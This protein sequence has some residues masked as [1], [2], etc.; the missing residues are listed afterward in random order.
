MW[1]LVIIILLL[2]FIIIMSKN[3]SSYTS[4]GLEQQD[5]SLVNCMKKTGTT[6]CLDQ[7]YLNL[8]HPVTFQLFSLQ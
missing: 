7:Y 4:T 8:G 6:K 1:V 2:L 3:T 5:S